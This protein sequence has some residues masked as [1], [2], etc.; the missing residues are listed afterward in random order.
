EPPERLASRTNYFRA[1]YAY[2]RPETPGIEPF[3]HH[4]GFREAARR[5]HGRPVVVPNIVYANLLLPGQELAV[6]TDVP[7]F[8]GA[9]RKRFP[10][11]LIV[12][13]HHSGLFEPWRMPIATAVAYFGTCEGG[14]FAFYPDGPDGPVRT[15][16]VKHDP[17]VLV[18]T[19]SVFHGVDR[20]QESVPLPPIR[21]GTELVFDAP[22]RSWRAR[23]GGEE[24]ATYRWGQLR[25]SVSWK[26]YCYADERER[27]LA[28][29]HRDDLELGFILGRLQAGPARAGGPRG[30]RGVG[31]LLGRLGA[32][33][34]ERGRL[35][36]PRPSDHEFALL[37]IDAYVRF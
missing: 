18:D 14:A 5:V 6:H 12:V 20:V 23:A 24:L 28:E 27:A 4:E 8:R 29:R 13:M 1:T 32:G 37:L 34:R 35:S 3:L 10:Q 7:E 11:W 16:P 36:G 26:A 25:F 17:G 31:L 19:D 30:A 33:L 2:D 21:P 22:S 15:L 9:N